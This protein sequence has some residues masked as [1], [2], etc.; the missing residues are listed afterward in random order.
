MNSRL[1]ES[2]GVIGT[3]GTKKVLFFVKCCNNR[4]TDGRT[5]YKCFLYHF[6]YHFIYSYQKEVELFCGKEKLKK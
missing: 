4:G 2:E 5:K 6:S 3:T 1:Y